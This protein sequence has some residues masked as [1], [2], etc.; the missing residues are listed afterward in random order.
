MLEKL[1]IEVTCKNG[2]IGEAAA[3]GGGAVAGGGGG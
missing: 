3:E 2:N 1:R